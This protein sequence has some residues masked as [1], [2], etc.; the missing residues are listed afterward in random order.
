MRP[1]SLKGLYSAITRTELL[2]LFR[3]HWSRNQKNILMRARNC[4]HG[5]IC[6]AHYV[7]MQPK[8]YDVSLKFSNWIRIHSQSA[9]KKNILQLDFHWNS[10][11]LEII[12]RYKWFESRSDIEMSLKP[13][14][15]APLL[16]LIEINNDTYTWYAI[17]LCVNMMLSFLNW[18]PAF[19]H[20]R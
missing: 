7:V 12:K 8:N 11:D 3:W 4:Y 2:F 20:A 16:F 13:T 19:Y 9:A 5:N 6:R 10:I 1:A 17:V 18:L 14:F 15:A